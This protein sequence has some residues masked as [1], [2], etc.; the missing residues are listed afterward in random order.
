MQKPRGHICGHRGHPSAV[1]CVF[2][3]ALGHV[4]RKCEIFT[5]A[6]QIQ[7]VKIIKPSAR[8]KCQLQRKLSSYNLIEYC[9][10]WEI[11]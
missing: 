8:L 5:F 4:L 1:F 9:F 7:L 3:V 2:W 11:S 6:A 10:I